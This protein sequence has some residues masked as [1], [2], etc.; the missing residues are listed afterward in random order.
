MQTHEDTNLSRIALLILVAFM[1]NLGLFI[2]IVFFA[3][4]VSGIVVGYI[5]RNLKEGGFVG[6]VGSTLGYFALLFITEYL[7]GFPTDPLI[8]LS[9]ILIMGGIGAF[10]GFVGSLIRSRTTD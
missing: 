1:L 7:T 4:F 3:P 6:F 8:I 10:G 2:V 5:V 9:A